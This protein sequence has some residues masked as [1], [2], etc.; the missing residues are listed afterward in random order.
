MKQATIVIGMLYGDEGKGTVVDYLCSQTRHPTVVVR[1]NGGAQAA[2][3]V[4]MPDGRHHTFAQFGSGTFHGA[5]TFL[6]RFMFVDPIALIHEANALVDKINMS[7]LSG[8]YIDALAPV[9]TPVHVL[10]NRHRERLRGHSA[11]GSCGKGIGE[12]AYDLIHHPNEVIRMHDLHDAKL[13]REKLELIQRRKYAEFH[14]PPLPVE[15]DNVADAYQQIVANLRLLNHRAEIHSLLHNNRIVF[16]GAQGVCLDEWYGFHPHTTWST[17]TQGNALQI[18]HENGVMVD[19]E[20]IGV[21]RSYVTRHGAGPFATHCDLLRDVSPGEHNK[22]GEFQG[23]FRSGRFDIPLAR[24]ASQCMLEVSAL[25]GIAMTHMDLWPSLGRI[26][27]R[28]YE[29]V[30]PT[31]NRIRHNLDR[32]ERLGRIV[33]TARPIWRTYGNANEFISAVEGN[34]LASMVLT[35]HGPTHAHKTAHSHVR[36]FAPTY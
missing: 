28:G 13:T 17:T 29:G 35:S 33:G 21:M 14:T 20:T 34:C 23:D 36:R 12:L 10:V 6:S 1:F 16:E 3:N 15:L 25:D 30:E 24:Y 22:R 8:L 11:H 32:Q 5:T 9:V 31:P 4:V 27:C 26:V 2:H 7:P 19:L 18:L